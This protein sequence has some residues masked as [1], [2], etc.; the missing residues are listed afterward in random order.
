MEGIFLA[1]SPDISD[2]LVSV[3]VLLPYLSDPSEESCMSAHQ[4]VRSCAC[5]NLCCSLAPW[6]CHGQLEA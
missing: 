6:H 3:A 1:M 4:V 2:F 5:C